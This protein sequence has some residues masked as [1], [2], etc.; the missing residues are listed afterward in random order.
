MKVRLPD[1][2]RGAL[3]NLLYALP[4]I[5]FFIGFGIVEHT[6][7]NVAD[8]FLCSTAAD[9]F[10]PFVPFTVVFYYLWYPSL[11]FVGFYLLFTDLPAYKR[12]VF[13]LVSSFYTA[14]LLY[15]VLPSGLR[16]RPEVVAG[17][18]IFS[19]MVRGMYAIDTP[20]NVFP[21]GHV[22]CQLAA[23]FAVFD[24]KGLKKWWIRL[25]AVLISAGVILSTLFIRQHS[26]LDVLAG[27]IVSFA[28][29][30]AVYGQGQRQERKKPPADKT[31]ACQN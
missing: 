12:Y 26:I 4:L 22:V 15:I 10:V 3:F 30:L 9:A 1:R 2:L 29:W 28:L 20:T 13:I 6:L 24:S 11:T 16:L 25:L 19:A 5:P 8:T 27:F 14:L 18:D 23:L 7:P 17:K 31:A 21:S